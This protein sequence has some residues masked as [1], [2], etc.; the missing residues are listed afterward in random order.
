MSMSVGLGSGRMSARIATAKTSAIQ[1]IAIQNSAP[2]RRGGRVAAA[3]TSSCIASSSVAMANPRIENGIEQIDDEV[4]H[5][6]ARGD[7]Q[8]RALQDDQI[9]R[10]DRADE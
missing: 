7:Q 9:A 2:S 8:H 1:P 6:E 10:V 5:H 3:A 4:H